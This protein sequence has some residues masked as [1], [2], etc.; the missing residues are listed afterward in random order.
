[1]EAF[2]GGEDEDEE[3]V[4]EWREPECEEVGWDV[5]RDASFIGD[6]WVHL[7]DG[8]AVGEMSASTRVRGK[9]TMRTL[10]LYVC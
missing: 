3:F 5:E 2:E 4:A 10:Q 9:E 1:V 7:G 8:C 6:A